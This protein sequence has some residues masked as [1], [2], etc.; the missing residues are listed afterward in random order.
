MIKVKKTSL[1]T[2]TISIRSPLDLPESYN[3]LLHSIETSAK[4]G[5]KNC[6]LDF[7]K[8]NVVCMEFTDKLLELY[9][10]LKL[11]S[12]QIKIIGCNDLILRTFKIIKLDKQIQL[13]KKKN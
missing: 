6:I 3:M 1:G 13:E 12:F 8:V 5:I 7:T 4:N 9:S 11:R 10:V 2:A